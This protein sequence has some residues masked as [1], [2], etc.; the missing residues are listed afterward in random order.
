M[1]EEILKEEDVIEGEKARWPYANDYNEPSKDGYSFE[2]WKYNNR[3]YRKTEYQN[4]QNNP[5]GPINNDSTISAMW[6]KMQI[7][8]DTNHTLISGD[9]DSN[10]DMT[11]LTGWLTSDGGKF[12]GENVFIY[13][14]PLNEGENRI[15]W[16]TEGSGIENNKSFVLKKA[17][18]N[19]INQ[20]RY[21]RFKAKTSQ[22]GG[23]ESNVIEIEQV[24][25]DQ[26]ILPDFDFLTFRYNWSNTDGHDLDTATFVV[27]SNIPIGSDGKTLQDY[28]VGFSCKGSSGIDPDYSTSSSN[29]E[30]FNEVSKYIKGG[31][32]NLQSGN[33]T[34]LINWKEICNRDLISQGINK[35][36][37]ELFANW[38]GER[39]NGNCN[40]T[41]ST[42]RTNSGNGSMQL[43][44]DAEGKTTF[45]FSP[46]GDT[47]LV[48]ELTI[49]GNVYASAAQNSSS[50]NKSLTQPYYSHVAT[51]VYDIR[52]KTAKLINTM[53]NNPT[54]RNL[55]YLASVNNI[56]QELE[57]SS[58][59]FSF[60]FEY[61]YNDT[62]EE[63]FTI[64]RNILYINGVANEILLMNTDEEI[65]K[66]MKYIKQGDE[67]GWLNLV[68]V[69]RKSDGSI[70]SI[71]LKINSVNTTGNLRE[72]DLPLSKTINDAYC[73]LRIEIYQKSQT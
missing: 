62:S 24:G 70:S 21:Y 60:K 61:E 67:G 49:S 43:D 65:S 13:D 57:G 27:G 73:S 48:T 2:G 41:F 17:L 10:T 71:T 4:E 33:E 50:V 54:G 9:G 14:E 18:P 32:D 3:I 20:S 1:A 38:Y 56:T 53:N 15:V 42:F 68:S 51:L 63:T 25:V 19:D 55:R 40:V 66:S 58:V 7:H 6:D 16:S 72:M 23:M 29:P 59:S 45:T 30:L 34:A 35:I 47:Q 64:D 11:K 28:P 5:F 69:N 12:T 39:R 46:T 36:Y 22:Y 44:R 37:C 8:A 26:T 52:S 31:G